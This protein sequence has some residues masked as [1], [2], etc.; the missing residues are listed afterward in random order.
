MS[1]STS[2]GSLEVEDQSS[3]SRQREFD[4]RLGQTFFHEK[5]VERLDDVESSAA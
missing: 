3:G 2:R 4:S 1:F 5:G